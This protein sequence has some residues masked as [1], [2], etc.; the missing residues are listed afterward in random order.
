MEVGPG[1][2]RYYEDARTF[3]ARQ[4]EQDIIHERFQHPS[5]LEPL[6]SRHFREHIA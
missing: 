6:L 3:P 1:S 4:R 2:P 5:D